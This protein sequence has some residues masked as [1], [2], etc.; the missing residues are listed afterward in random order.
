M[1]KVIKLAK[2][3]S[4]RTLMVE[5][6]RWHTRAGMTRVNVSRLHLKAAFVAGMA[7]AQRGL[8]RA[9]LQD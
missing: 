9:V 5:R 2:I 4:F 6:V 3:G 7:S 1:V 8:S